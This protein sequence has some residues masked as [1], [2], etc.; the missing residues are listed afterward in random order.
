MTAKTLLVLVIALACTAAFAQTPEPRRLGKV[1]D[2]KGL[3]TMSLG[4]NVA[5][6]QKDI[7]IFN[8]ARFVTSSSGEAWLR[9]ENECEVHLKPNERLTIDEEKDCG[10]LIA[11]IEGTGDFAAIPWLALAPLAMG[12][13]V[14]RLPEAPITPTPR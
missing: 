4:A 8:G 2:V 10:A 3:V 7:P 11:G 6:V 9:F 5:T 14:A 1:R 13:A 12:A